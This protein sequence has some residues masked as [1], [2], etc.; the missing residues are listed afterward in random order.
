M[1]DLTEE[2]RIQLKKKERK[3][4]RS[5]VL[6]EAKIT[7]RVVL[8]S[9]QDTNNCKARVG[10]DSLRG[11]QPRRIRATTLGLLLVFEITVT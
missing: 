11:I 10:D 7:R 3:R 6:I 8:L 9:L 2:G 1:E 4:S 5:S